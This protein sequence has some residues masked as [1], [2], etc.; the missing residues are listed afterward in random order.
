MNAI[1]EFAKSVGMLFGT[2]NSK[3]IIKVPTIKLRSNIRGT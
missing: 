2:K 1:D 3:G